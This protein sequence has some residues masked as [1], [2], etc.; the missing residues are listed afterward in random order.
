M[1]EPEFINH[2]AILAQYGITPIEHSFEISPG[3]GIGPITFEMHK[4]DVAR[5]FTYVYTSFFKDGD[6]PFRSDCCEQVGLIIH[7]D[8]RARVR[9]IETMPAR[10]ANTSHLLYGLDVQR[11]TIEA[12]KRLLKFRQLR[13]TQ[14]E[15]G[16]EV[17]SLGIRTFHSQPFTDASLVESIVLQMP[18]DA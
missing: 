6:Q 2:E 12:L 8:Q 4:D 15:S 17:K 10:H 11:A 13:F 18:G 16:I 1:S 7:Y 9:S 5:A 3:E 14:Y